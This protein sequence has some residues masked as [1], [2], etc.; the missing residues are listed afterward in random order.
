M[1]G[2]DDRTPIRMPGNKRLAVGRD[3]WREE[4]G[5]RVDRLMKTL[6][7]RGGAVYWVGLPVMRR[8]ESNDDI[9]VIND[10]VRERAYLNGIKYVDAFAGFADEGGNYIVDGPDSAGRMRVMRSPDGIGF[11]EAGNRKLA[12]FVEREI[13]RDLAQA[14]NERAIP[15]AGAEAEQRKVNPVKAA[16]EVAPAAAPKPGEARATVPTA[17]V[18]AA[19]AAP[20]EQ[21]ADNT[22]I[23]IRTVTTAGRE[24]TATLDILRPAIAASVIQLIARNASSDKATQVGD[25]L[26]ET[27]PGGLMLLNSVSPGADGQGGRRAKLAPTQTAFFRVMLKGERLPPKPGRSDDFRWP[28]PDQMPEPAVVPAT[29]AR[30]TPTPAAA[31]PAATPPKSTASRPQAPAAKSQTPRP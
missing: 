16:A 24:E 26:Q 23:S 29:P 27:L 4:Y 8:Q 10:L 1:V 7:R 18:P 20:A 3:D 11:T 19:P 17:T 9:Q 30:T 21:K 28:R 31:T 15:L 6:K 12:H 14:K 13:R 5:R 2:R 22:R 25:T